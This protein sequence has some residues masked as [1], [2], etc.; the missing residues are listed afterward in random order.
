MQSGNSKQFGF[1]I[2][3]QLVVTPVLLLVQV[4]VF[5]IS[6]GNLTELRPWFYFAAAYIHYVFSTISS[7]NFTGKNITN[8]DYF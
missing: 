1:A 7:S 2:I 3:K 4:F 5:Y 8:V 6:A